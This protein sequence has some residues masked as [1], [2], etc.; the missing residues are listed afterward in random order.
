[1]RETPA[2][3]IVQ[4]EQKEINKIV[5]NREWKT[6]QKSVDKWKRIWYSILTKNKQTAFRKRGKENE[7]LHN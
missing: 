1:M 5:Q 3:S 2:K 6:F 4:N 7:D